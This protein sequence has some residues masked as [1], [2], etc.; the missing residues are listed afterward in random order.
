MASAAPTFTLNNGVQMPGI[1][2]GSWLGITANPAEAKEICLN[3]LKIGYR[4]I[5]T[6]PGYGNEQHIGE[7]IRES[8]VPRDEVFI[9]TKLGH[10]HAALGA[11]AASLKALDTEYIDLYLLHWP[12]TSELRMSPD[13]CIILE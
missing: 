6:A 5:D 9:C 1:G 11:L 13:S 12:Q 7:A 2:A 8:G 4:H 10:V 3:A